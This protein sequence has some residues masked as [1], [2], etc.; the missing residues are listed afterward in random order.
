ML[1]Q[2]NPQSFSQN[3]NL[4]S[5]LFTG[6]ESDSGSSLVTRPSQLAAPASQSNRARL[7]AVGFRSHGHDCVPLRRSN[8]FSTA[9]SKSDGAASSSSS[10][11]LCA[12]VRAAPWQREEREVQRLVHSGPRQRVSALNARQCTAPVGLRFT[13]SHP[14]ARSRRQREH[15]RR[16][17]V[18]FLLLGYLSPIALSLGFLYAPS[19][20]TLQPPSLWSSQTP[21]TLLPPLPSSELTVKAVLQCSSLSVSCSPC[22][23]FTP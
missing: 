8:S 15:P 6:S 13:C 10:R 14:L 4:A 21:A 1:P 17:G 20:S 5:A 22:S 23:L 3:Q 12:R 7:S 18:A 19:S 9:G 2:L 11:P 16:D